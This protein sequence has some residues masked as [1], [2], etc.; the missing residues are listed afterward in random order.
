MIMARVGD[1]D[2]KTTLEIYTHV[3]E[4]MREDLNNKLDSMEIPKKHQK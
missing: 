4:N 2:E 1:G 3:T